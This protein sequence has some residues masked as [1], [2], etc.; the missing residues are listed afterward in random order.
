MFGLL[1]NLAL[2]LVLDFVIELVPLLFK[3][4]VTI[5]I[6]LLLFS[7]LVEPGCFSLSCM[8]SCHKIF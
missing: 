4:I 6:I 8:S 2:L 5:L 3:T 7:I 1:F